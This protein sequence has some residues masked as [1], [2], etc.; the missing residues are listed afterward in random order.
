MKN[1]IGALLGVILF[2][3]PA[4]AA[5]VDYILFADYIN[6]IE[7]VNLLTGARVYAN[8]I[9]INKSVYIDN[10]G[11]I[12]GDVFV[13]DGCHVTLRNHGNYSGGIHLGR[14]A[15]LTQIVNSRQD[16][17]NL[18]VDGDYTV[19]VD[20]S[21][22][23]N[24]LFLSDILAIGSDRIILDNATLVLDRM[25][26][27][28]ANRF[29]SIV[30]NGSVTLRI[31]DVV[32]MSGLTLIENVGGSGT[33]DII[34]ANMNP[35]YLA[36]SARDGD[37]IL[38]DIHRETDYVKILDNDTGRFLNTLRDW[39]VD[40]HL[41]NKLDLA[42][43]YDELYSILSD[44]VHTNPIRLMDGVN[45]LHSFIMSDID[46]DHAMTMD[47]FHVSSGDMIMRGIGT[48]IG[49]RMGSLGVAMGG[50]M[51]RIRDFGD[52]NNYSGNV[53]GGDVRVRLDF[54]RLWLRGMVGLS[55]AEF[56][57]GYAWNGKE[58][59]VNPHGRGLYGALDLGYH[60]KSDGFYMRPFVGMTAHASHVSGVGSDNM[61]AGRI[62]SK[63]GYAYVVDGLRYDFT[64]HAILDTAGAMMSGI[65]MEIYSE[66]DAVG[67]TVSM[68][69]HHD[70]EITSYRLLVRGRLGF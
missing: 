43:S 4:Y 5:D 27:A 63:M 6:V 65:S 23:A 2:V 68:D 45:L 12:S 34:I 39:D 62:G 21:S 29:P 8:R 32:N 25:V 14:D 49:V 20:A 28:M 48:N 17:T 51:A 41:I 50:H 60:G 11:H 24:N 58:V 52:L 67:A 36:S 31:D 53:Y 26:A 16:I 64:A 47:Y 46:I 70:N 10:N 18:S 37:V 9:D 54:D 59:L 15:H 42:T 30:L 69:I 7:N 3:P 38:L 66:M 61:V 57:V 13:A 55:I 33:V 22:R 1:C 44:S 56:D 19:L 40:N 35:L